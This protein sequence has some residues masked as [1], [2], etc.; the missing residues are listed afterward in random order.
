MAHALLVIEADEPAIEEGHG[1]QTG[2][3]AADAGAAAGMGAGI[4]PGWAG[5]GVGS[6]GRCGSMLLLL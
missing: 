4:L 3:A 5:C 1:L 2:C 6:D